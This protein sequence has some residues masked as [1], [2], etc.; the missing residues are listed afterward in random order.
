MKAKVLR[1]FS[2]VSS[3][4]SWLSNCLRPLLARLGVHEAC[5]ARLLHEVRPTAVVDVLAHH[6][7]GGFVGTR[8]GVARVIVDLD[9]GPTEMGRFGQLI[10]FA[11]Q[12]ERMREALED[13]GA[14]LNE[15]RE[16]QARDEGVELR[17]G[18]VVV[19]GDIGFRVHGGRSSGAW[20]RRTCRRALPGTPQRSRQD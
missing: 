18:F 9:G 2:T 4:R 20:R 15:V 19:R 3:G 11:N 10:G 17:I 8:R 5:E 7:V 6:G 1:M 13:G 14:L 16:T 12:G